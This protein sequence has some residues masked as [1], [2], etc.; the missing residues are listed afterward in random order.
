MSNDAL[1]DNPPT[2]KRKLA[3]VED[4][5]NDYHAALHQL[6]TNHVT[7]NEYDRYLELPAST[8]LDT[9]G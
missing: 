5:Q 2:K 8:T 1:A 6:A 9:L 4:A 7:K 3:D